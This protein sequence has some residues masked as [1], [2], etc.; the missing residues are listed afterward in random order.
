M[1][2]S[3]IV[4]IIILV[5]LA[6]YSVPSIP[7]ALTSLLTV[8]AMTLAGAL[9]YSEAISGF[10]SSAVFLVAG[11]TIIGKACYVS[12]LAGLIGRK[13]FLFTRFGE[14]YFVVSLFIIAALLS[15]VINAVAIIALMMPVLDYIA[16]TTDNQISRKATYFPLGVSVVMGTGLSS[17]SSS[18]MIMANVILSNAGYEQLGVFA[19][20]VVNL[21]SLIVIVLFY[22]TIGNTLQH[23]VFDFKEIP[24]ADAEDKSQN[25]EVVT[26]KIVLSAAVLIG[27]V[28]ALM[29]GVNV[30]LLSVVGSCILIIT[31]CVSGQEAYKSISWATLA[32]VGASIGISKAITNS[33]A[34]VVLA[35]D[36]IEYSGSF[37]TTTFGLCIIVFLIGSVF[38]NLLADTA[39]VAI[40]LPIIFSLA[41][42]LGLDVVALTLACTS[43][44]K[45]ALATPVCTASMTMINPPGYRFKDYFVMGG[46]V[47]IICLIV[48]CGVIAILY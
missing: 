32:I 33:G 21:P 3:T 38:S 36:V 6:C 25:I 4:I 31:R 43:G 1:T 14:R 5:T 27:T 30:G 12:G 17:I 13:L 47:N 40:M 37:G 34:A 18:S 23:R 39:T 44:V 28:I 24:A 16:K 11:M 48:T 10:T 42:K 35:N 7:I 8:V 26:W 20:A 46:L 45:F 29:M 2:L 15:V 22:A 9:S 41:A 19:P